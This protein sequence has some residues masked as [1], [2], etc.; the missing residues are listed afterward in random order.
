M[1]LKNK[2]EC[3]ILVRMASKRSLVRWGW[4]SVPLGIVV[5]VNLLRRLW[6]ISNIN[7]TNLAKVTMGAG[8]MVGGWVLGWM[9]PDLV[10]RP[11]VTKRLPSD[12][13][14]G[15]E[16]A[17]WN[18]LTLGAVLLAGLWVISSGE[19][20]IS[21]GLVTGLG[22]RLYSTMLTEADYKKWYWVFTREFS[23]HE[24]KMFM[25]LYGI[26]LVFQFVFLIRG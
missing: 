15:M 4:Q 17:M 26:L 13:G 24:H 18:V 3:R 5:G 1:T 7:W 12:L 25:V 8:M 10:I 16:R 9:L 22:L 19:S 23:M 21:S 20:P 2:E 11:E 14:T 6:P